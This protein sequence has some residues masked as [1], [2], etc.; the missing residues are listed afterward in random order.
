M[1]CRLRH[2]IATAAVALLL[3]AAAAAREFEDKFGRT[4]EAELVS[5]WGAANGLVKINK[6]GAELTVAID[7]F[8]QKHKDEILGWIAA[9][10]M[11]LDAMVDPPPS[12]AGVVSGSKWYL[13]RNE[14]RRPAQLEFGGTDRVTING[15]HSESARYSVNRHEVIQ[16]RWGGLRNAQM[17]DT[18]IVGGRI[19]ADDRHKNFLVRLDRLPAQITTASL[20]GKSFVLVNPKDLRAWTGTETGRLALVDLLPEG[21]AKVGGGDFE[22]RVAAGVL[23][24]T[25]RDGKV[26]QFGACSRD[27]YIDSTNNVLWEIA[28]PERP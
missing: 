28:T 27:I 5:H 25:Q 21:K 6:G 3:P 1:F 17:F 12:G 16:F 4:I 20:Q 15:V 8:A 14:G 23:Q 2:H 9:N 11:K 18:A 19:Y 13:L 22:W 10:P 24:I 7:A 26:A